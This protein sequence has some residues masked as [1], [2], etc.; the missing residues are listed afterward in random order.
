V[1]VKTDEMVKTAPIT[2]QKIVVVLAE[3]VA[4]N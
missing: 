3:I 1:A 4:V 2:S